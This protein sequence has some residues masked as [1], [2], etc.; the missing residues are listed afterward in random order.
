[1]EEHPLDD[2]TVA[3][4]SYN[5]GEYLE[6]CLQSVWRNMPW[7][8]VC[9]Y[10]DDSDDPSTVRV[11]KDLDVPVCRPDK[12]TPGRHGGLYRNM[13][14]ALDEAETRW[15]LFLQEDMQI[16]RPVGRAEMQ[17][18]QA[19]FDEIPAR[20][21][22]CPVFMKSIR[23]GRHRRRMVAHDNLRAYVR[24][25]KRP[26]GSVYSDVAIA[27][28]GRLR[29]AGWR[30]APSESESATAA[31]RL[32]ADMPYLADPF[33]FYCPE[34]PV[35]RNR[36]QS[37]AAQLAARVTGSD[38]KAMVDMTGTQS[39]AFR[40]RGMDEWPVAEAYLTPRNPKV[41][42]PFVYKDV[43]ARWWL[44]ALYQIEQALKRWAGS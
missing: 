40:S 44:N 3:V 12:T 34:V 2:L 19:L 25:A 5:R 43:K 9:V 24:P 33:A 42:R 18:V 16:V 15:I 32:F 28:V 30:F 10:D 29:A 23:A 1:V 13:Q 8:R 21:F 22:V 14:R 37:L 20:A 31:Q 26:A 38:I 35:F 6:N 36:G 41:R 11:L 7:A 17:L 27:D 4:F 39:D